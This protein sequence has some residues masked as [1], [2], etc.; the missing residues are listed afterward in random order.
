MTLTE[1]AGWIGMWLVLQTIYHMAHHQ[2]RTGFIF[3]LLSSGAW[4]YVAWADHLMPLLALQVGSAGLS[5]RGL[6][7]H[8]LNERE[9]LLNWLGVPDG[10]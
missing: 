4:A 6:W 2:Y 3:N 8:S 1:I 9:R 10:D 7:T 5:I